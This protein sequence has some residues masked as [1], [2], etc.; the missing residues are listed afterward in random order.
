[1]TVAGYSTSLSDEDFEAIKSDTIKQYQDEYEGHSNTT[2]L[3][4]YLE[5][6]VRGVGSDGR[7]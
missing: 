3:Y 4:S 5:S 1:M 2:E 7:T 6:D